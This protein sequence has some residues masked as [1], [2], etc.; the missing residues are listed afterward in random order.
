MVEYHHRN[1]TLDRCDGCAGL[2]FDAGELEDVIDHELA[3]V[4]AGQVVIELEAELPDPPIDAG[5]GEPEARRGFFK[6]LF[7]RWRDDNPTRDESEL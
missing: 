4:A 6:S 5:N 7:S 3:A 2:F 1:V